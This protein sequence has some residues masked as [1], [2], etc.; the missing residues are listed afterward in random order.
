MYNLT[1]KHYFLDE[2]V[3]EILEPVL[4]VVQRVHRVKILN[5]IENVYIYMLKVIS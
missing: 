2:D 4:G 3:G 5:Y 1:S